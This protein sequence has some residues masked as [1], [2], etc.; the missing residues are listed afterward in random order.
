[1]AGDVRKLLLDFHRVAFLK[2]VIVIA[3]DFVILNKKKKKK[4][5]KLLISTELHVCGCNIIDCRL[6]FAKYKQ[7]FDRFLVLSKE[8]LL[9]C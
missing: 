1:M 9:I 5:S 2:G 4:K 8:K 7:I 6:G 3:K